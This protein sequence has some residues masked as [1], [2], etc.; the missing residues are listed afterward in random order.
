ME[1]MRNPD[2]NKAVLIKGNPAELQPDDGILRQNPGSKYFSKMK[3]PEDI[4]AAAGM[5]RTQ[6]QTIRPA[7]P[8]F[9]PDSLE[10]APTPIMEPVMV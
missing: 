7:T 3:Q 9:I 10:V 1:R 4:S 6:A 2:G 5:V 8:H